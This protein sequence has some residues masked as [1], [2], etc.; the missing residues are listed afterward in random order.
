MQKIRTEKLVRKYRKSTEDTTSIVVL[1]DIDLS[2]EEGEFVAIMG[3]SGC[4]K[5]TLIK[6]LGL[7]DKPSG[8]RVFFD[9]RNT[10]GLVDEELSDIRRRS[11]GFVFQDFYLMD[12]LSVRENIMLPMIMDKKPSSECI[13]RAEALAAHFEIEQLLDKNSYDL[14]GGEKQRVAISR[15]LVNDPEVILA[16]EPTGNLDTKSGRIVID[17]LCRINEEMGKT[18]AM[19]TH[20]AYMASRCKRVI[21]LKD[22][23]IMEDLVKDCTREEFYKRIQSEMERLYDM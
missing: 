10:A 14:S 17:E 8:G 21:L 2:I 19:V 12:S 9:G 1:N 13:K 3:K 20:D 7:I 6:T 18:I 16:D 4:G 15:A 11:I 22:G 5:T 23:N